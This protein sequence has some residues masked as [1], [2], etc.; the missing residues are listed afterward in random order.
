MSQDIQITTNLTPNI[1]MHIFSCLEIEG[2]SY[3]SK[4][5]LKNRFTLLKDDYEKWEKIEKKCIMLNCSEELFAIFYQIPSY[6]PS[7]SIETIIDCFEILEECI[8]T[9]TIEP[10]VETYPGI[11]ENLEIYAP[12]EA[13]NTYFQT[14]HTH[15]DIIIEIID[16]YK[17][18]LIKLWDRFYREYWENNAKPRINKKIKDL[19]VIVKPVNIIK[20]WQKVFDIPFPYEEFIVY[21][22]E[23]TSTIATNLIAEKI[24][25]ALEKEELD[26]YKILI[27]EIGRSF[28]LTTNMMKSEPLEKIAISNM[29]KLS[30]IID[31]A[32]I[33]LKRS[34]YKTFHLRSDDHDP[35]MVQGL[36]EIINTFE[37][38]WE[39]NKQKDIYEVLAKTYNKLSPIV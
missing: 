36:D 17:Q 4:Y 32:I 23:P 12:I 30:L 15:E 13:Y 27:H 24:V 28:L 31:A 3:H 25:V 2:S 14:L 1:I 11:F 35:Y 29:D 7:D 38:I 37:E 19:E 26:F 39:N 6:I 8:Q 22:V 16:D 10:L 33:Y 34:L 5:G 20:S 9:K 21:L 18:L